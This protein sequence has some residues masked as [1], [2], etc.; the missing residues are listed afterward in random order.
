MT[1]LSDKV[2]GIL[3]MLENE[4]E[5]Y[6]FA[7]AERQDIDRW[8][9]VLS[10]DWAD[11]HWEKALRLIADLLEPRLN[12]QEKVL[13]AQIAVIP[14][15]DPNMQSL[16]VSLDGVVPADNKRISVELLGSDIR[17]AFIFKAKHPP[18]A[19]SVTAETSTGT[20]AS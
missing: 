13:I 10:A 18:V 16:P 12:P 2:A 6:L 4:G 11:H 14:S 15:N 7:L 3:P 1:P 20:V 9:V 17:S 8:D 19:P 5:V